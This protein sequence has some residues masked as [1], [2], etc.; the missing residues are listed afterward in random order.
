MEQAISMMMKP[1]TTFYERL[2]A[3]HI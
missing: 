1:L 2:P 3:H